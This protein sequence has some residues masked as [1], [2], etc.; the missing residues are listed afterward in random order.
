M[1]RSD[2][3]DKQVVFACRDRRRFGVYAD[4]YIMAETGVPQ[5]VAEAAME[6][7]YDRGYI[8]VGVSL[9]TAWPTK[10]GLALLEIDIIEKWPVVN[11]RDR[12]REFIAE[13][14]QPIVPGEDCREPSEITKNLIRIVPGEKSLR[15]IA[16]EK[17]Q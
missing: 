3:T 10:E 17:K 15:E 6:R 16:D 4:E 5:K 11:V 12:D 2:V 9:R 8:E 13:Q 1:K 14:I 7:A